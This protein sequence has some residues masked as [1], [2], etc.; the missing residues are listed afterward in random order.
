[1]VIAATGLNAVVV[2]V[3]INI[4]TPANLARGAVYRQTNTPLVDARCSRMWTRHASIKTDLPMCS[5]TLQA[6]TRYSRT[7]L[8]IGTVAVSRQHVWYSEEANELNQTVRC[9]R[10]SSYIITGKPV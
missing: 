1:M 6:C 2:S 4:H 10:K 7:K 3:Q 8:T 9:T 5:L